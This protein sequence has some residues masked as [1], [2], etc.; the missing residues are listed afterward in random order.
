MWTEASPVSAKLCTAR[1][2][3]VTRIIYYLTRT[4]RLEPLEVTING[5]HTETVDAPR[6]RIRINHGTRW[7]RPLGEDKK[8]RLDASPIG[9]SVPKH[10][11]WPPEGAKWIIGRW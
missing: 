10:P 4:E 8:Q 6:T 2:A 7:C 11:S 5:C 1:W 3:F 9:S